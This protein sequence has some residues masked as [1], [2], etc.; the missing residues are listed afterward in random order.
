MQ[1]NT[2]FPRTCSLHR[3][4]RFVCCVPRGGGGGGGGV[5]PYERGGDARGKFLIKPLKEAYLGVTQPF[6]TP[7]SDHFKL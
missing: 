7:K 6:L 3:S 5:L 4:W 1:Q 2:E